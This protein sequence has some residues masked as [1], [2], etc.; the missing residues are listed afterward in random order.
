MARNT[1]QNETLGNIDD[2]SEDLSDYDTGGNNG[3]DEVLTEFGN[4]N[5]IQ[6][7]MCKSLHLISIWKEASTLRSC[8]TVAIVLPSGV[9]N[10]TWSVRVAE[11]GLSLIVKVAWPVPLTNVRVLHKKWLSSNQMA[12]CH[13]CITGFEEA[14]Q[15]LRTHMNDKIISNAT[16][17]LPERVETHIYDK[18]N[19]RFN[20]HGA[21]IVYVSL[22]ASSKLYGLGDNEAGFDDI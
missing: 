3:K 22:K 21:D 7:M 20:D 16:I 14:L 6:D 13:P 5:G 12:P 17:Y 15:R 9:S 4:G 18:Q 1:E 19:L 8:L 10:G 2:M 11:E